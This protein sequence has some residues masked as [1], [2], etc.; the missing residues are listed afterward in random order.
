MEP[1]NDKAVEVQVKVRIYDPNTKTYSE[2]VGAT[3]KLSKADGGLT[4]NA[5]DECIMICIDPG[6][7]PN[8]MD[9][10]VL[11]STHSKS[12]GPEPNAN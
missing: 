3:A 6:D 12:F 1:V 10:K 2:V 5:K 8:Y 7:L 9:A 4:V 11:V